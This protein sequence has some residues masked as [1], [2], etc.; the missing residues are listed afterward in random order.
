MLRN[1]LLEPNPIDCENSL[2]SWVRRIK[3]RG[4]SGGAES[5]M[6]KVVATKNS[7]NQAAKWSGRRLGD[8]RCVDGTWKI[9]MFP[10]SLKNYF[11]NSKERCG[12]RFH[13]FMVASPSSK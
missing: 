1:M 3:A 9:L 2:I 10:F 11:S 5:T 6:S 13:R 12:A 4:T 7:L 8:S